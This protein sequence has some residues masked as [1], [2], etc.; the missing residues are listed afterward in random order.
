M[1]GPRI[2]STGFVLYGALANQGAKTP[3]AEAADAFLKQN[4]IIV[5]HMAGYGLPECLR[6]TIGS[7][8]EMMA[9]VDTLARFLGRNAT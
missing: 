8:P 5:R 6:I 3:D 7:E 2:T 1:K 4:G 9:V